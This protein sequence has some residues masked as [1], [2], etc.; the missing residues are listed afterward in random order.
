MHNFKRRIELLQ[1]AIE[2]KIAAQR[3]HDPFILFRPRSIINDQYQVSYYPEGMYQRP[4]KSETIGIVDACAMLKCWPGE[5]LCQI[6]LG[7]CQE[8]LFAGFYCGDLGEKYTQEQLDRFLKEDIEKHPELSCM[9]TTEDGRQMAEIL[10]RAP[11]TGM[12]RLC[13]LRQALEGLGCI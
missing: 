5:L 8:W 4:E 10:A 11:Q 12:V 6:S 1:A 13:D 3:Q 2:N 9:I 7:H